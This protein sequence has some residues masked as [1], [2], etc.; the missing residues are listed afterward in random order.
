MNDKDDTLQ[1]DTDVVE[2]PVK[3][4]QRAV[5]A[6]QSET[7]VKSLIED[8][9]PFLNARV[10]RYTAHLGVAFSDDA[11]SISMMAL[12]EAVLKYDTVK[13][14][15][16]PFADRV[17]R[18]RL[19]DHIRK[20]SKQETNTISLS[21]EDDYENNPGAAM[22]NIASLRS[23]D[24]QQRRA[25]LVEEI[26]QFKSELASWGLTMDALTKSSPK[27]KALRKTYNE[28]LSTVIN[29][30]DII[31]TIN[32]KRYFPIKAISKNT[33]LPQKKLE[34]ARTYI[35]AALIIKAGDYDLLSEFIEERGRGNVESNNS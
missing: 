12:H 27:H 18:A 32:I 15:F 10:A 1:Q 26:E 33:G 21:V 30:P 5:A 11:L 13:G 29:S 14:H 23:Y 7:E 31:Q 34:R 22:I 25:R 19:I 4:N 3:L 6:K 9:M 17:V 35:L 20:V 2:K 8:F 16:F 24:E 28:I